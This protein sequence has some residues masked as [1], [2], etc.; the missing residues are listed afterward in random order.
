MDCE[1]KI[2]LLAHAHSLYPYP[3]HA[4]GEDGGLSI[5]FMFSHWHPG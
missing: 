1:N 5:S 4:K 3:L 2:K